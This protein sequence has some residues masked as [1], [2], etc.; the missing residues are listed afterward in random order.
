M[1]PILVPIGERG[2]SLAHRNTITKDRSNLNSGNVYNNISKQGQGKQAPMT[3]FSYS[4]KRPKSSAA[5][6][7]TAYASNKFRTFNQKAGMR[8]NN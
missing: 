3:A 4:D 8:Q 7:S 6:T 5:Y 2:S 1:A